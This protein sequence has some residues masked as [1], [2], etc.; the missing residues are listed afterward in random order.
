MSKLI[1]VKTKIKNKAYM[2][3]Y[4]Y[5]CVNMYEW[6]QIVCLCTVSTQVC[7]YSMCVYM[8]DFVCEC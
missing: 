3:R 5:I 6:M 1:E 2:K 4:T 7:V 8:R